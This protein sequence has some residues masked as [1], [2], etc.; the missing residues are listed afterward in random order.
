MKNIMFDFVNFCKKLKTIPKDEFERYIKNNYDELKEYLFLL[1][2]EKRQEIKNDIEDLLYDLIEYDFLLDTQS[3]IV[4]EFLVL[5]AKELEKLYL[6]GAIVEILHYLPP[7]ATYQRLEASLLYLQI[8][9]TQ[10]YINNF[11]KIITLIDNSSKQ[12]DEYQEAIDATTRFYHY[13]M[14]HL[15][16]SKNKQL[17]SEFE[18]LFQTKHLKYH[19]LKDVVYKLPTII[20]PT[21][22]IAKQKIELKTEP[23]IQQT[24]VKVISQTPSKLHLYKHIL[25]PTLNLSR[26][27]EVIEK[28]PDYVIFKIRKVTEIITSKI[29]ARY[30][31]NESKISQNDKIRYLSFEKTILNKK[32]QSHLHTIRTIGN[33]GIHEHIDNPITILKEDAYFLVTAL[34]LLIDELVK[35]K[36]IS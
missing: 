3:P 23:T 9:D 29:Y 8:N 12:E 14:K 25:E 4:V 10:Q 17:A 6:R 26:L 15:N 28:D 35:E 5:V 24:K 18:R 21:K 22:P 11:E 20:K 27:D 2:D 31:N 1:N 19:W 13:A 30:E 34:S 32:M 7:S 16:R 36:I 33:I